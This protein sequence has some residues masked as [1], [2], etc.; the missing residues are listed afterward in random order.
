MHEVSEA[1][2][3]AGPIASAGGAAALF[4]VLKLRDSWK[5]RVVKEEEYANELAPANNRNSTGCCH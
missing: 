1:V 4:G 3:L 2:N 5:T